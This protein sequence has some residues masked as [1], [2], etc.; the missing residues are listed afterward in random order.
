MNPQVSEEVTH[1]PTDGAPPLEAVC[2]T[3]LHGSGFDTSADGNNL[4]IVHVVVT[5]DFKAEG[6]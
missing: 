1:G 5:Q 6:T 4:R 3:S 2:A